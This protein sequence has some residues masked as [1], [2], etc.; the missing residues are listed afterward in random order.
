LWTAIELWEVLAV[1]EKAEA[2]HGEDGEGDEGHDDKGM[3][4]ESGA[5]E[6]CV[7]YFGA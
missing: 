7:R 1:S 3:K 5:V 4:K 6:V 2:E